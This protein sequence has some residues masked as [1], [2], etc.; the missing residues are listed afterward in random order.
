[1]SYEGDARLI[2]AIL[3]ERIGDDAL[4]SATLETTPRGRPIVRLNDDVFAFLDRTG[5]DV[6]IARG[7]ENRA[8][9]GTV[10]EGRL[11][12]DVEVVDAKV[13]WAEASPNGAPEWN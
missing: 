13:G 10:S 8:V 12:W 9:F 1:M 7:D 6:A 2:L 4:D 3:R 11:E 5:E